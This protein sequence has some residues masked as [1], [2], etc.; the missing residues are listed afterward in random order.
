QYAARMAR[1]QLAP[2]F[3]RTAQ[4]VK[5]I[6]SADAEPEQIYTEGLQS[7]EFFRIASRLTE[8]QSKSYLELPH[9]SMAQ[10]HDQPPPGV[11]L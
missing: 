4:R 8:M 6:A 7:G 9:Q 11:A 10:S 1:Q 2:V 3:A 5:L